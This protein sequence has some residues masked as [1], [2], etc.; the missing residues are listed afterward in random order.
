M[1]A[2]SR[3]GFAWR[4]AL[5]YIPAVALFLAT[6]NCRNLEPRMRLPLRASGI[7]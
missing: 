3:V 1:P 6:P 4:R 2:A 5:F 7:H